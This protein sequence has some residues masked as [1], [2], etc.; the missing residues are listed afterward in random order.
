V[1][2]IFFGIGAA[3]AVPRE[4]VLD[5][6]M[7]YGT[8]A[9]TS[10]EANTTASCD[11]GYDSDYGPGTWVGL[12][13]DWGGY[14]S[15]DEF[16]REIAEGYGAGSH[17]WDGI[18]SCTAGVDCSGFVSEVWETDHLTTST[19][20]D[21]ATRIDW[22]A[23]KRGDVI[24]DAGSHVVLFTHIGQDGWPVFWEASGSA[25]KVRLNSTGGWGYV[26]GYV[27]YRFD[28]IEEGTSSGTVANPKVIAAFPYTDQG[29][30]AGAASDAFDVYSCSDAD[31]S[32]PEVLYRVDLP[33]AGTL[34]AVV[35]DADGVDI[36]VQVLTAA[37]ADACIGR[38][39]TEVSVH[40]DA[41]IVWLSLDTYVGSHEE[42]GPY[43]LTVDF[44]ADEGQDS[45][46]VTDSGIDRDSG[47]AEGS[48]RARRLPGTMERLDGLGG[49]ATGP[50]VGI[51]AMLATVGL[52]LARR[53]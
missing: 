19:I 33:A 11:A 3:L 53:R 13:Y 21:V 51:A 1:I 35:S 22:D 6:A 5:N 36:D 29:W 40:V 23:L 30:T 2:G 31:E 18:L 24:D 44:T 47:D 42:S 10:T 17:S 7:R 48:H 16:D 52:V 8:H 14:M 45:G 46:V 9:W 4:D 50:D 34:T 15:L 43:L 32:G 39:D 26:D 20:P 38:D 28:D 49:C 37:D 41:G 25:S 27:P 12:P